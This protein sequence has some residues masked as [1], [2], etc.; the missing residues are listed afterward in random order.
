MTTD[1]ASAATSLS[2]L[3]DQLEQKR[4]ALMVSGDADGLEALFSDDLYYAHSSGLLD[5]KRRYIEQF[6]AGGF[7]YHKIDSTLATVV[8]LGDA[9]FQ[10]SGV[11]RIEARVNGTERRMRSIY[12]V[13]WRREGTQ[14]RLTGH[15]TT[16]QPE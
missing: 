12:F 8:P 14:W 2:S 9:A 5:D 4:A 6:R 10:A 3:A 16:L 13:V 15:Q 1:P 11:V 7:V